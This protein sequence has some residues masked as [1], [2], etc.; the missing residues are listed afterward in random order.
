MEVGKISNKIDSDTTDLLYRLDSLKYRPY[1]RTV[2][3]LVAFSFFLVFWDVYN[4]GFILPMAAKQLNVPIS[5]FLYALPISTG[6]AGY[7]VG[8]IGI[9]YYS[10]II[11]RR[12]SLL[13]TLTIAAVGSLLAAISMNFLEMAI[14]RFIIGIAIGAEIAITST[15]VSEIT[16]SSMRGTYVGIATAVGMIEILPVGATAY[17]I[18]PTISW[19]WRLMFGIGALVAIP[20]IIMRFIYLPESPRWLLKVGRKEDAEN[21]I[22][23]MEDYVKKTHGNI[24]RIPIKKIPEKLVE[25]KINI[26]TF[27]THKKI[28]QR[29]LL[30]L[31]AWFFYYIGDYALVSVV[32]SLFVSHGLTIS[33]SILYFFLSSSGDSVGSFTGM[34]I[35]DKFERKYISFGIMALSMVF[36]IIWGIV[37]SPALLI[38][39]GFLVFFT[40]GLWLP[41]MY[42]YSAELFPTE[43]RAIGV[44]LTDGLGHI[45]GVIAPY[46]IIPIAISAGIFGIS[47]YLWA[48]IVM[49]ITALIAGLIVGVAGPK[50]NKLRLEQINEEEEISEVDK[51]GR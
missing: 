46:I 25:T 10:Q 40:Q 41:V 39:A 4:I 32:P 13:L 37:S 7:V 3:T 22:S 48:F 29:L 49:G 9:G 11:G 50:T 20:L 42:S 14:F 34:A 5:S 45:G 19:G 8:E 21:V 28:S 1:S 31:L 38:L 12:N 43:E 6:L 23:K 47:G 26:R 24:D 18:V 17:F 35:S 36:F 27:F 15:Y 33:T 51:N 44:G 30:L 16:P 2:I